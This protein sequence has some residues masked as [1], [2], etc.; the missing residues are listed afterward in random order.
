MQV[1]YTGDSYAADGKTMEAIFIPFVKEQQKLSLYIRAE[2][3]LST[4]FEI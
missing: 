2:S 1:S 4:L 3:N